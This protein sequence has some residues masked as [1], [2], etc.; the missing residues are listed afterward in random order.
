MYTNL[1]DYAIE[2]PSLCTTTNGVTNGE[3]SGWTDNAGFI[4]G[5][6]GM[7]SGYAVSY[8]KLADK[9]VK[10]VQ[11]SMTDSRVFASGQAITSRDSIIQQR[12]RF[13]SGN[14]LPASISVFGY[15]SKTETLRK[16]DQEYSQA[17][18]AYDSA[19][20]YFKKGNPIPA[21]QFTQLACK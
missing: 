14:K 18:A 6:D 19:I 16:I 7:M 5:P 13:T 3:L 4:F 12:F 15:N 21:F 8:D 11:T 1:I 9:Q 20:H 2:F 17:Y 10:I